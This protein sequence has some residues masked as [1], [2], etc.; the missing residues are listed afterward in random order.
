MFVCNN[1]V[2]VNICTYIL[3]HYKFY[4]HTCILWILLASVEVAL[5]Q[6]AGGGPGNKWIKVS[7]FYNIDKVI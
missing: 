4:S 1:T 2:L 7:Q 5:W 6:G 3:V